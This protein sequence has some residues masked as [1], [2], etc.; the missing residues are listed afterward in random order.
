M[1]PVLA[2]A[3]M[4]AGAVDGDGPLTPLERFFNLSSPGR[5]GPNLSLR[6]GNHDRPKT[7]AK[8]EGEKGMGAA[9]AIGGP[10]AW[11]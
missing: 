7:M 9:I 3:G 1:A 2:I 5:A 4:V 8:P 6:S 10:S 11:R